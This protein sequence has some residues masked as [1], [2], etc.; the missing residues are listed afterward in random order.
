MN[1]N[2]VASFHDNS[3][4]GEDTFLTRALGSAGS[5]DVILDGVTHSEG[6]YAS[7]FTAQVLQDAPIEGLSDLVAALERANNTLFEKGRRRNPL[8]T[9][10]AALKMGDELHV[11]SVGDSPVYLVR[12]GEACELTTIPKFDLLPGSLSSG[13]VGQREKLAYEYKLVG[14]RPHDRLVLATDGLV[15]NVSPEEIVAIIQKAASPDEAVSALAELVGEKRSLHRGRE[16]R[17][18][19]FREDDRTAI[20]RY[21]D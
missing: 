4:H 3:A 14:L 18:G 15:N 5:L 16:D 12:D 20:I 8:T 7:S 2:P 13:A 21:F 1:D 19:T 17:Y 10:S 9:V 6:G 11:V